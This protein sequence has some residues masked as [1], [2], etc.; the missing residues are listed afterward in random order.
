[1]KFFLQWVPTFAAG[2]VLMIMA[3][4]LHISIRR[5]ERRQRDAQRRATSDSPGGAPTA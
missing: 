1:M 3:L 4:I 2:G 5:D